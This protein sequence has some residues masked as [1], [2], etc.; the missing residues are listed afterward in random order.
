MRDLG[1]ALETTS[2]LHESRFLSLNI[3]DRELGSFVREA[4]LGLSAGEILY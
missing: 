4:R 3:N 2:V 1:I